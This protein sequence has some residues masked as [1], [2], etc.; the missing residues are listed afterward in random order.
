MV[1]PTNRLCAI[2][3]VGMTTRSDSNK[4]FTMN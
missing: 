4:T 1:L 3:A 2:V